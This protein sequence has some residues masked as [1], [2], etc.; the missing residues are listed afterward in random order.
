MNRSRKSSRW[1]HPRW[2]WEVLK[3][4]RNTVCWGRKQ[5]MRSNRILPQ[6][7]REEGGGLEGWMDGWMKRPLI[8][9]QYT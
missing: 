2:G 4:K 8:P 5:D 6:K 3:G 1:W 7:V 9:A